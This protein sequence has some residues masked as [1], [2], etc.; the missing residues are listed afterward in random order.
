MLKPSFEHVFPL[1]LQ[2]HIN[3]TH[4]HRNSTNWPRSQC[5]ASQLSW[6]SIAPVS[7]R[8][9]VRIPLKPCFSQV[10]F[11]LL[12]LENLLRWSIFTFIYHRN[13]DELFHIYFTPESAG[14]PVKKPNSTKGL[15]Q[16]HHTWAK[17][18][19]VLRALFDP[20][21]TMIQYLNT[22]HDATHLQYIQ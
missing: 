22:L 8:S 13:S 5:V 10:S 2:F 1:Q 4:F 21:F 20:Y 17:T 16:F 19:E 15:D 9:R 11:Q 7:R 14:S 18:S 6:Y 3:P 12:K